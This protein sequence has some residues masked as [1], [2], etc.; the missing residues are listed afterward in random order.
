MNLTMEKEKV[1]T[2]RI[3]IISGGR[4]VDFDHKRIPE[5]L[6]PDHVWEEKISELAFYMLNPNPFEIKKRLVGCRIDSLQPSSYKIKSKL[7]KILPLWIGRF[8]NPAKIPP[9]TIVSDSEVL[10]PPVQDKNLESHFEK[11]DELLKSYDLTI[12]L[13]SKLDKERISDILGICDDF[14][15]S[16]SWLKLK[17]ALDDKIE[18]I[19]NFLFKDVGV[20]LGSAYLSKG[21]FEMR[22]FDFRAFNPEN[23]YKLITVPVKGKTRHCVLN[24]KNEIEFWVDNHNLVKKMHLLE[25]SIKMDNKFREAIEFCMKGDAKPLKIFF[26]KEIEIKYSID[27]LPLIYKKLF[28]EYDIGNNDRNAIMNFLKKDQFGISFNCLSQ[29]E[30]GEEKICTNISVMHYYKALEPIKKNLPWLYSEIH[31]KVSDSDAGRF[32]LLDSIRGYQNA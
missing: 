15:G 31:K 12:K 7:K 13:L 18:Y 4:Y 26:N 32:Y 10:M 5:D 3:W 14:G 30:A 25:Q 17:G 28:D 2:D 8:I 11:L 24:L 21:L 20:I 22:G 19:K 23:I 1:F 27:H 9:K 6:I 29:S 16:R